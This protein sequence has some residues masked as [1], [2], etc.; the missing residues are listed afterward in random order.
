MKNFEA[1]RNFIEEHWSRCIRNIP[2][3]E[4][5]LIGLPY[6]YVV[7]CAEG[8]F[9]EMYYW[10]TYFTNQG[11]LRSGLVESVR[12]NTDNMLWLVD[13]YGF[14]PNGNRTFYLN[15]SQPPYLSMMVR[16]VHEATRDDQ[17]LAAAYPVLKREYEFWMTR[18]MTEIG[19]NRYGQHAEKADLIGIYEGANQRLKRQAGDGSEEIKLVGGAHFMAECESGWDFTPRFDRRCEDYAPVDLNSNLYGYE[20]NF[21]YFSRVLGLGEETEW[22]TRAENRKRLM[23]EYLWD[24]EAG[25]FVDYDT[26]NRRRSQ[27]RTAAMLFPLWAGWASEE[28]VDRLL[29]QLPKIEGACGITV[30]EKNAADTVYQ[31]D[32]PN[33]WAPHQCI[34]M[35][36]LS[37]YGR[38]DDARRIAGKYA[39]MVAENFE[40]TGYL[41]EKYN[42]VDGSIQVSDE[43]E[44]PT[45]LGWTA[46]TFLYALE[47]L[48]NENE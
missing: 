34:A 22:E 7:P 2:E 48:Q 35:M 46:G 36:G 39:D 27:M 12:S 20:T 25:L 10:D 23:N 13:R 9:Q 19:L 1:V 32:Y 30:C 4:G 44:M 41:W 42:G 38:A 3:D 16:D 29:S 24:S 21:A 8:S 33:A 11:L 43:Y 45:M 28:Q 17:W 14:M 15:R 40:R 6:P 5:T 31:W 26:L 37:R 18:R 47:I